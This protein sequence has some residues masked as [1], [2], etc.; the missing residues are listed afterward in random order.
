MNL[1]LYYLMN[2]WKAWVQLCQAHA[3]LGILRQVTRFA[4]I[5]LLNFLLLLK[6]A[7]YEYILLT[8]LALI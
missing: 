7:F 5:L 6:I 8:I 3:Q 1:L 2:V 4:H